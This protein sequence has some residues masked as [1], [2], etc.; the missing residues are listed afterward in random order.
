MSELRTLLIEDVEDDALLIGRALHQAG[1]VPVIHRV[2]TAEAFHSALDQG[3]WDIVLAD[4]TLPRFSALRALELLHARGVFLPFIVVTGAVSEETAVAAMKAGAND[5]VRKDALARLAPAVAR[6][7][8]EVAA[9][10]ARHIADERYRTLARNFPNGA[11]ILFDHALRYVLADGVGLVDVGLTKEGLEGRTLW[12]NF[13][14]ETAAALEPSYRAAL[15]GTTTAYDLAFAGHTYEVRVLPVYEA[16]GRISGGMVMTQDVTAARQML[17]AQQAATE[18]ERQR[19]LLLGQVNDAVISTDL[20][21]QIQSWNRAAEAIYGWRADEV[22]GRLIADVIP[23]H[24]YLD[25]QTEDTAF[26]ALQS[27]GVWTGEVIHLHRDGHELVIDSAVRLVVDDAGL[28]TGA[29]AVNRDSTA[30]HHAQTALRRSEAYF[31]ALTEHASDLVSVVDRDGA[32]RYTSPAQQSILG[33][34]PGERVGHPALAMIHPD[35]LDRARA[36][37]DGLLAASDATITVELRSR[38]RDGSWRVLETT[39]TNLLDEPAVAGIV[40]NS[41]DITDRKHIES[42]L[43]ASEHTMR[44]RLQRLTALRTIDQT[45]TGSVDLHS[46]LQVVLEQV[47]AQLAINA[48]TILALNHDTLDLTCTAARGFHSSGIVGARSRLGEGMAGRVAFERAS[49]QIDDLETMEGFLRAPLLIEEGFR[50]YVAV[51][52]VAKGQVEGVL[53]I[54]HRDKIKHADAEWHAFMEALAGQTAIAIDNSTLF[55]DVQ[56]TN[57]ELRLA[58]TATITGWSN[59]LDLR[60]KETEGHSQRVTAMTVRLAQALGVSGADLL[61]IQRGALLHDIGKMGIPDSI[62]LKAGPL[63]DEEWE[64]MRRHPVYAYDLLAPISFLQPALDIPYCHHEKWDGTGYP[65]G[66]AGEQIPLAARIFAVADVYDALRSNRPYRPGWPEERVITHIRASAGSHFDPAVVAVFERLMMRPVILVVD[67]EPDIVQVVQE[68]LQDLYTVHTATSGADALDLMRV[69]Q[70]DLLL[71]DQRM[72]GM[73]G[74]ELLA[75]AQLLQPEI[76]GL[77]FSAAPD[78]ESLAQALNLGIVRGF[79]SKPWRFDDLR[80]RLQATL[81]SRT[82]SGL[83]HPVVSQAAITQAGGAV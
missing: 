32:I 5:I 19:A 47:T 82:R 3:P 78:V 49:M 7:L 42:R 46:I 18:H 83:P 16:N 81:A 62:L 66:L 44:Q 21:F 41:R 61:Q 6:E 24:R 17:A 76:E 1:Y 10:E 73:T 35:D 26:A 64:I 34:Q 75:Q 70:V 2:E 30:R 69:H 25:D 58:Y 53:E 40:V 59:A 72:P 43:R 8:R 29:V 79:I 15:A 9:H 67:D 28:P 74:I 20:L 80:A 14:P 48:A 68:I 57:T 55:N 63:S 37:F 50:S 13:P 51:P 33:F 27:T 52:L 77:L 39:A 65:R 45:I 71:T 54:F 60:D 38:H 23:V 12:D 22:L 36:V 4:W 56:R 11:V 31:R